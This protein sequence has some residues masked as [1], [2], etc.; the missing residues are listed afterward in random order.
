M[1][2]TGIDRRIKLQDILPNQLP[3]FILEESPLTSDFLKQY[4][5]SQEFQGG[6][7]DLADNLDQYLNVDNLTPDVI[8]GF[9]TLT[10]NV[11]STDETIQVSTTKGFPNKYGLFK[12]DNE[13]VTYTGITTNSF[14]GCIRGFSGIT[15][16]HQDLN[17]EE[18]IFS[19]STSDIHTSGVKLQN[20][21]SL[22]L[23]EFYKKIKYTFTPGLEDRNFHSGL[24]VGN[25]IK[26]ARSLYQTKGTDESFRI[27]FNVLYNHTPTVVNL[28]DYLIKPSSASYVRRQIAIAEVISGDPIK[29]KGQSLFGSDFSN[30]IN[31]SVSEV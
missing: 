19:D 6:P 31:A 4:Y 2:E 11:S 22:F 12:I 20:L 25:F 28:E 1:I 26:E 9:T 21:S 13:V 15:S 16:Y 14:T 24:D 27:L 30:D 29:L 17:Y 18:L 23:Q 3:K 10:T 5:I 7:I 8:V